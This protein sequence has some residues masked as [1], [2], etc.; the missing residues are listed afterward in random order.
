MSRRLVVVLFLDLVGWTRLAERVDPEPLQLMLEQYYEL[1]SGAVQEHG[2]VVEKFIGDAVM[3]VFGATHTREDD[4]LRALRAAGQI[5]TDVAGLA[6]PGPGG[7]PEIHCGIAAG[8]ALVTH[9]SRAGLRVVG[10]VVNLAA[11]LQSAAGPGEII[12]NDTV[13]DLARP[14]Y[15][16]QPVPP[17]TLKGKA[18]PVPALRVAGPAGDADDDGSPMVDRDAERHRIRAAY[19]RVAA[20]RRA[21]TMLLVGA[22]GI[23]K[24]RL[25]REAVGE[26][27]RSGA[28]SYAAYGSCPSYGPRGDAVALVQVLDQLAQRS[29]AVGALLRTRPR[30]AAVLD[31]VRAAARGRAPSA[32]LGA[33]VE[34]V[35]WAAREL[36]TAAATTPLVVVWDH[37]E[38]AGPSLLRLL[39]ELSADLVRQPVLMICVAR[40]ELR[41]SQAAWLR[42]LPARDVVEVAALTPD[43]SAQLAAQLAMAGAEVQAHDLGVV[44]RVTTHSA[45][46]PLFIR[47][48]LESAAPG[49]PADVVP[50]TITALVGA[51]LDRLP[52]P[53]QELLAA[54]AVV[55]AT[56]AAD[57]LA[58][59]GVAA[60]EADLDALVA[61]HLIAPTLPAGRYRFVQQ[62]VHEVAYGRLDKH[63]RLA[64]HRQ[65]AEHDISPAFHLDAAVRLLDDLRPDDP[66]RGHLARSAA[67]A[68]LR[69][70]TAALR[71]RDLPAAIGLLERALARTP[72]ADDRSVAAL[73]LSDAL[74]LT[75]DTRGAL[76]AAS[77]PGSGPDTGPGPACRVQQQVLR[78]R[79]GAP[80]E[81]AVAALHAEL[82]NAGADRLARCRLAQ[83]DMLRQLD[84]GRFGA[85]E[86]AARTAL[87]HA[88][89]AGD[90]YEE[91]RLLVA[92][93]EL[94]QWAPTPISEQL[95]ACA[96]LADRFAADRFLLVPVLAA[97]ARGLAL[98]GDDAGVRAALDEAGTAVVELRLTMGRVL[99]DQVSGLV[100]SFAGA[101]AEAALR[102][103]HAATVLE[104]AGHASTALT[105]R[106]QAA[107]E[108]ARC[109]P[110]S[111]EISALLARR[112]EMD[113]RGRL[114]CLS[115]A[116]RLRLD[117]P[118]A[119]QAELEA[120]LAGTD[121][122][123][124]RG[125]VW[126]ELARGHR[127]WGDPAAA[128]ATALAAIDSYATVGATRPMGEVRAWL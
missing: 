68:L 11:R 76:T 124:L 33:G 90:D 84:Q 118:A 72:Q 1:C 125:D 67:R 16:M 23:G 59:L 60:T 104:Q 28:L 97:R 24:T 120:L 116:V 6:T 42:T 8:E 77:A 26:L 56:F 25:A 89:A 79:L 103:R 27:Q 32:C 57:E 10:D 22:P 114:L 121:D 2:G 75:G 5:R 36:I 95:A 73:R 105:L 61:R 87:A 93:C 99:I 52:T 92:L 96:E 17:L 3:A 30:L 100:S 47:L 21:R 54:A 53:A 15:A 58:A 46:N 69:E 44:D 9:S 113:A 12:V 111:A 119:L 122:A 78:A 34:E 18:R 81:I 29:P 102:Y 71:Q 62:P 51:M 74:L 115:T 14:H 19:H 31:D 7:P 80:D 40:P 48:M 91:D 85:A 106:V 94:R 112:A 128:R 63:Q 37:L 117:D 127:E 98:I 86:R 41:E 108:R 110:S 20:D 82:D 64:W 45:G 123:V 4:A 88:R 70:G 65:L 109:D 50:P 49:R 107:R 13:A 55:G 35:A 43:D 39:G 66:D 83:V 126:A 101:H 38:W